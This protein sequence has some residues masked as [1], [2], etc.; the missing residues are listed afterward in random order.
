MGSP[1]TRR[2]YHSK[3]RCFREGW[4]L[5]TPVIASPKGERDI[6][7]R[8][9]ECEFTFDASFASE[10]VAPAICL[11]CSVAIPYWSRRNSE[12]RCMASWISFACRRFLVCPSEAFRFLSVISSACLATSVIGPGIIDTDRVAS[13][14]NDVIAFSVRSTPLSAS[15]RNCGGNFH[16]DVQFHPISCKGCGDVKAKSASAD[17]SR[18]RR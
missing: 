8:Q 6:T 3:A 16:F 13:S 17:L 15:S 4:E 9:L 7:K 2:T 5:Q 14:T 12:W 11:N 18:N 1:R 10:S